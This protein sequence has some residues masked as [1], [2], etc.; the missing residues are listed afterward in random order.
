SETNAA[1][2]MSIWNMAESGKLEAQTL[3]KLATAPWRLI[4]KQRGGTNAQTPI[5]ASPALRPLLDDLV[6]EESYIEVHQPTNQPAELALA[7]HV[8]DSRAALWQK[9]LAE[10]VESMTGSRVTPSAGTG[11]WQLTGKDPIPRR[12]ELSRSEGWTIFGMGNMEN[13]L[14][15]ELS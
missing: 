8:D 1:Y 14:F 13:S 12:F 4:L 9:N 2:F 15:V 6:Q 7:I 11:G 5:A 10:V 3:D